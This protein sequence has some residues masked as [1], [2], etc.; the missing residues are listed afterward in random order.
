MHYLAFGDGAGR[1]MYERGD[2]FFPIGAIVGLLLLAALITLAIFLARSPRHGGP[3]LGFSPPAPPAPVTGVAG[4]PDDA[5][6]LVRLRYARGEMSRDDFLQ[7]STDLGGVL[8]AAP[9]ANGPGDVATAPA[10]T[11]PPAAAEPPPGG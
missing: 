11:E 10:S 3:R 7:T 8:V 2:G 1:H 6:A 9:P 5:L 4:S